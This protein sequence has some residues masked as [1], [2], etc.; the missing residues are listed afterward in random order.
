VNSPD[1]NLLMLQ[2]CTGDVDKL[3]ILFD[4]HHVALYNF[5][6]KMTSIKETSEDMVQEVFLRM[7]KY[8]HSFCGDGK[9]ANWMYHIARNVQ[10]DYFKQKQ[11]KDYQNA[12]ELELVSHSPNPGESLEQEQQ[13]QLIQ[14]A[15]MK[16]P[17]E[18]REVLVLS[19]FQNKKYEEIAEIMNCKVSTI[20]ARVF[21]ALQELRD[22]YLELSGEKL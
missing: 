21:R 2:I 4:R 22:I 7:L 12:D 8:R 16:L 5:F 9:F 13:A 15:L 17:V 18:K 19:R 3:S 11:R 1:D 14:A 10:Y 6:K 20:K